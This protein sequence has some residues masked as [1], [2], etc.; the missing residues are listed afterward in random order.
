MSERAP[1]HPP[2]YL[3]GIR[4]F[5][6]REYY[7]AHEVWES[8]W[9]HVGD[10]SANFYKGLIQAAVATLHWERG[11]TVG[12][13]KLY[14]SMRKYLS[15]YVPVFMDLDVV[16]FLQMMEDYFEPLQRAVTAGQ[17]VPPPEIAHPPQIA[18]NER[19]RS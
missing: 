4:L 19:A 7:E 13:R 18:L 14:G 12:A 8:R 2:E 16:G 10:S 5:N 15:A 9:L 6:H 11:N 1:R 17:P 3:E